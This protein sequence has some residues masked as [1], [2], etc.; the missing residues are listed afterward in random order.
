[1]TKK[2]ISFLLLLIVFSASSAVA[3]DITFE[4][5]AIHPEIQG[6][7][8]GDL[9]FAD[10][11]G[12]GDQD[13]FVSGRVEGWMS[14]DSTHLYLNDGVG[15]FTEMLGT[16]F[17]HVQ[18]SQNAFADVDNDG[19]LDLML[20]GLGDFPAVHA[21]LFIN[22][23]SGVFSLQ[24][25]SPFEP[26]VDAEILFSDVD[27]DGDL[28]LFLAGTDTDNEALAV[29]YLNNG[30]GLYAESSAEFTEVAFTSSAFLDID[31]DGD[32]DLL[33]LLST[34]EGEVA[35]LYLNDG[36]GVFSPTTTNITGRTSGA[37]CTGDIDADGDVDV[38]VTG[39][40]E[41][42]SSTELYLND[43]SGEMVSFSENDIFA[44]LSVG[45]NSFN[46]FDNDGDLDILIVGTGDG[47]VGSEFGINSWVYENLGE[48]NYILSD[49]LVG[50]YFAELD[51]A[52]LNAD[53]FLD[54][55]VSGATFGQ[56]NFKTWILLNNG[57]M[58]IGLNELE[59][60]S[61]DFF[62]NPTKDIVHFTAEEN[63]ESV[64][65]HAMLGQQLLSERVQ[66]PIASLDLSGQAPGSYV[67]IIRTATGSR[68]VV[69]VKE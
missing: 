17:P 69:V 24:E 57:D 46:D 4:V 12:D 43:G 5:P 65:L 37:L 31:G 53:G 27:G 60:I 45:Q 56:P 34:D 62:P 42:A 66:G 36:S 6:A 64:S 32:Q 61:V 15:G 35:E 44:Q 3:Q 8:F 49:S 2:S 28:D 38:L 68:S 67:A 63:I 55:V 26:A 40:F 16:P 7:L 13:L 25:D 41:G 54:F 48:N 21:D 52:D 30:Q 50:G 47:G 14:V 18:S 58:T 11:D 10:V 29:L 33:R 39:A 9:D 20:T 19:D 22:D 23:G 51:V 1:M 59:S